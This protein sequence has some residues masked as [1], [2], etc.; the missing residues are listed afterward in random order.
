MRGVPKS[1][2]LPSRDVETHSMAE[3]TTL[4]MVKTIKD[5]VFLSC[6]KGRKTKMDNPQPSPKFAFQKQNRMQFTD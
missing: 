2:D 4:G 5:C 6:V 3:L 1:F